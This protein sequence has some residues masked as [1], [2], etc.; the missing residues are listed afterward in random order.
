MP[1]KYL[2]E[3]E[4]LSEDL[5]LFIDKALRFD[6]ALRRLYVSEKLPTKFDFRGNCGV[7]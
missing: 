5:L 1:R 4:I 2:F 3:G 7:G 6:K